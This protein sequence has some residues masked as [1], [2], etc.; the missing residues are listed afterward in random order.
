MFLFAFLPQFV[1]PGRGD[2]TAQILWL[3]LS[4]LLLGMATDAAWALASGSAGAWIRRNPRWRRRQRYVSA[5]V[6]VGLGLAAALGARE[7]LPGG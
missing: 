7:A 2:A 3:G 6:C 1:D 5:A 4:F